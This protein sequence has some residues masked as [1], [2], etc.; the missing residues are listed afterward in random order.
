MSA[1]T[2]AVLVELRS[3]RVPPESALAGIALPEL[4]PRAGSLTTSMNATSALSAA[5]TSCVWRPANPFQLSSSIRA[6]QQPLHTCV[7]SMRGREQRQCLSASAKCAAPFYHS[8]LGVNR[9]GE[10]CD[11]SAKLTHT[12]S[13]AS[14]DD[15]LRSLLTK[16]VHPPSC[17]L[18]VV[19]DSTMH[20][21]W[22]AAVSGAMGL[23]G[24]RLETCS[25]TAGADLWH[26]AEARHAALW[27]RTAS[28]CH[29]T[30]TRAQKNPDVTFPMKNSRVT[31]GWVSTAT[32]AGPHGGTSTG[33]NDVAI[34]YWRVGEPRAGWH[35]RAHIAKPTG[36]V[37]GDARVSSA[38][39]VSLGTHA[40]T[41]NQ[42]RQIFESDMLPLL[43]TVTKALASKSSANARPAR[44]LW[45]D[46]PPQH[47]ATKTGSGSFGDAVS[48]S[49]TCA[50]ITDT[51]L[52]G[53]R[54]AAFAAWSKPWRGSLGAAWA[55]VPTFDIFFDRHDLHVTYYSGRTEQNRKGMKWDCTHFCFSPL[56]YVPVWERAARALAELTS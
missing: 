12:C 22:A 36:T 25:F 42:I 32:F 23:P 3:E 53:W 1:R 19:G 43:S 44:L 14:G 11:D 18:S 27:N 7:H 50:P 29:N 38:I 34:R 26:A 6:E 24:F 52:A 46:S 33:C 15:G 54:N 4:Q 48:E 40:N 2:R 30:P 51:R 39:L 13:G 49:G 5:S 37:I 31:A 28:F 20:D 56:L 10:A 47:F 17:A 8:C 55:A 9:H 21:L 16:H 41:P 45:L 35:V